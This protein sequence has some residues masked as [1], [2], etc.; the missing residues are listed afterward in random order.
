MIKKVISVVL[1]GLFFASVSSCKNDAVPKPSGQLR[2][3]YPVPNYVSFENNC[4][5]TFDI[6]E[7]AII[8]DK[9]DCNFTISYPKMKATIFL[10]YK[11]VKNDIEAH[12][13]DAQKLTFSHTIKADDIVEQP[14]LNNKNRVYGMFYKVGGNAA[15]NSLFY[16]TD[17]T[18][19][20]VTGSAY[21]YAKPNFDSIMPA[22]DYVKND[23]KVIME[24]LRWK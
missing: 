16:V 12:L 20:F 8:A 11:P 2:L 6:N 17:S 15:T 5:F 24:T 14:F 10:T 1:L 18:K 22:S 23:M 4:P 19:Y 13:R 7:S 21:F 3:E 9:G